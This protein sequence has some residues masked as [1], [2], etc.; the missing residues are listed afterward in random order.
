VSDH[1]LARLIPVS[2]VGSSKEA[3]M[4]ATSALLAVLHIVRPFSKVLLDPYGAP[5]AASSKVDTYIETS[6]KTPNGVA[7]P[8]GM[9]IVEQGKKNQWTALVEVKTGEAKL[10][11]E[12][13]NSS[14]LKKSRPISRINLWSGCNS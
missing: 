9:I 4:R 5:K 11:A 14:E 1:Q 10:D 3:E 6:F 12:Q 13:V 8:D 7:R 2:H